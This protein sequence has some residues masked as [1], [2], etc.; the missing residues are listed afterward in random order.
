VL[1]VGKARDLRARLRSYFRSDRQRPAVE[2]ALGALERIEWRLTGSEL[3]AALEELKLIRELRPPANARSARPDRYLYLRRRGEG[4][5]CS[6]RPTELGPL[7]SRRRAQLAARALESIDWETP[8]DALPKL[9]TKLKLLARD[10]RF[11]DAARLRDRIEALEGVV[12]ELERLDRLRSLAVCVVAPAEEEGRRRAF[13][14]AKGR[15]VCARPF[16]G[17]HGLE[18]QAGLAAVA[19][20]EP[21]LDPDA[22]D[23][24]LVIASFLRRPPPELEVIPLLHSIR[25]AAA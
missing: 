12:R 8:A 22:A 4:V 10:L 17:P 18:W 24:L 13:Y 1:Y 20:A 23:D 7:K 16:Q 11:E 19:R 6:S 2:S 5:V 15:V 21:T 3:E 14:V 9:R 25:G